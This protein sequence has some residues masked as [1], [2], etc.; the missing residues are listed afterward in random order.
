MPRG[1]LRRLLLFGAPP[2][3]AA[4]F[5]AGVEWLH[6]SGVARPP[7]RVLERTRFEVAS[8]EPA[9][10]VEVELPHDWRST[11]PRAARARYRIEAELAVSSPSGPDLYLPSTDTSTRVRVNGALVEEG[12][13]FLALD[14]RLWHVPLYVAVPA[15]LWR[16]GSNQIEIE[17]APSRA[18]EAYLGALYLGAREELRPAY[19]LRRFLQVTGVQVLVV[20]MVAFALFLC[21]LWLLRRKEEAALWFAMSLLVV[22][23]GFWNLI[24]LQVWVAKPSWNWI[25]VVIPAW[26]LA[27][28]TLFTHRLLG[29]R[30][31]RLERGVGAAVLAG[32]VFFAS[33]DGTPL[34]HA[35]RPLWGAGVL[36]FGLY[37]GY[38]TVRRAF[39]TPSLEASLLLTSGLVL[40]VAGAH[41]IGV[42][43]GAL[44]L[45]HD[46]A[47][48]WAV[49]IGVG[50]TAWVFVR[51]FIVALDTSEA[52]SAELERRVAD[53][54]VELERNY[55]RLNRLE[56]ERAVAHERE[57]M[58][59]DLHDGLGGQLVSTLAVLRSGEA[60]P[61]E[62]E[63]ALQAALDDMRLLIHSI[64]GDES[65]LV[66]ALAMLRSRLAPRLQHAGLVLD[67]PVQEVPTP[68]GFGP[69]KALQVMRVVQ[70]AIANVLKHAGARG[71]RVRA[72]VVDRG[73]GR[74][75]CVAVEDDGRG[76]EAVHGSGRGLANMRRRAAALGGQLELE[77]GPAGT[78]VRLLLPLEG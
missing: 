6:T 46:M 17:L 16:A 58:M 22:A 69:E 48:A 73:A 65:D 2:L 11:H 26:L 57:R 40:N 52:L 25:G 64:Q 59:A 21:L 44:S 77:S 54:H 55:E 66:G 7:G 61:R 41:D 29:V 5:G 47:I 43:N 8:P 19:E 37:P 23:F 18:G 34:Y 30:R 78:S 3:A 35:L 27:T 67:W 71:L 74:H 53:K 42:A 56:R 31:P 68:R 51:R 13:P 24:S 32:T 14:S 36:G 1:S 75:V 70:E 49:V 12:T 4:M 38:L 28:L 15:A 72:G 39:R 76:L 62:L 20:A 9:G 60:E 63:D 45:E 10:E 50:L 33:T